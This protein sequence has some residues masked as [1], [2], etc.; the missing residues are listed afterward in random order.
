MRWQEFLTD[1]ESSQ[2]SYSEV[3]DLCIEYANEFVDL[4]PYLI[5]EP[6]TCTST[7]KLPKVLDLFRHF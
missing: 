5:E 6:Y 1:F 4:R 7:D 3:K 2:R